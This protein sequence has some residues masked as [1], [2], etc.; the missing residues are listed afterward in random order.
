MTT[1][2]VGRIAILFL[3][4]SIALSGCVIDVDLSSE[5]KVVAPGEPVRFDV[6]VTNR[7]NCP[8][9]RVVS[10]LV[11]FVPR[12]YFIDKIQN[13]EARRI[14]TDATDA[15][16]LGRSYDFPGVEAGCRI[17]DGE[18]ICEIDGRDIPEIFFAQESAVRP[19]TAGGDEITCEGSG[20]SVLCHVPES[21][22]V[23]LLNAASAE[24][25]ASSS[26]FECQMQ[27]SGIVRCFVLGLDAG[28]TKSDH[29][30]VAPEEVGTYRNWILSF[31]NIA[32]GVCGPAAFRPNLPCDE[33][34]TPCALGGACLPGICT[35]GPNAGYGCNPANPVQCPSSCTLCQLPDDGEVFSGVACTTATAAFPVGAP[36]LS[37][38]GLVTGLGTLLGVGALPFVRAH[39]R[40]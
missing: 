3:G 32:G 11:P 14:L 27:P 17:D 7:A 36:A 6:Q 35:A 23:D 10:F 19:D 28:E 30:S 5:P 40:R 39:R 2:R 16:C 8:V 4:A 31:A 20:G 12:N 25:E 37:W 1:L 34:F 9:G 18:L 26:P 15:F 22:Y 33:V 29:I 24:T 13:E 21:M 38:W